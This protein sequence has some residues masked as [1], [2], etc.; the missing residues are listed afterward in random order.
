MIDLKK[1]KMLRRQ[2]P[3]ALLGL[4]L[5]GSRLDGVVLKRTNGSLQLQQ[6]FS[7][8]LSLDPLTADPELVGQEIR[9]HLD[10]A[11]VRE[12]HCVVCLPLKW[13]LSMRA[14]LP[15]LAESDVDGFLQIEAEREFPCDVTT[16]RMATSRAQAAGKQ[17]AMLIGIP[18]G[19]I[20]LL[21]QTLAKARLKPVSFSLGIA[22]LQPPDAESSDG[23]LALAIGESHLDLQITRGGGVMAMR[24]IEATV[25]NETA[26]PA[27]DAGLVAREI[28][29]TLGQFPDEAREAVRR[30]RIFGPRELAAQL[31]HE[32][33]SR[34]GRDLDIEPVTAYGARDFTVHLPSGARVSPAFSLA[35]RV[36]ARRPA[37]FEFL[38]PKVTVWQQLATR[39]S[40]GR[41]RT[42]GATP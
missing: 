3:S 19:H 15:P 33:Q 42:A 39:Y 6:S 30:I 28:R 25:G 18:S 41:L 16:L 10:A 11:G 31:A 36:L 7:V 38:P 5:D 1:L 40:S 20:A 29:I 24:R 35:A 26:Q 12:R 22:A 37:P 14:E 9:N 23:V 17:H 32:L 13:A 27:L 4:E 8:T 21:E 34:I 2:G